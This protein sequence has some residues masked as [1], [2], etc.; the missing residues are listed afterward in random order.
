MHGDRP[1]ASRIVRLEAE[2]FKRLRA[3]EIEPDGNVVV[4]GG[5]NGQ[6]K[7]SLLDAIAAAL[8]GAAARPAIP[9]RAGEEKAVIVADLGDIIV[10]RVFTASGGTHLHVKNKEGAV[11]PSPQALLDRLAGKVTFDPLSF[12][13]QPPK[14]Q[15]ETLKQ[16]VGVDFDSL[17]QERAALY[18]E[19]RAVNRATQALKYQLDRMPLHEDVPP[20]AEEASFENLNAE[21]ERRRAHNRQRE[22][23]SAQLEG[24]IAD[25]EDVMRREAKLTEEIE[26]L[27]Q[28]LAHKREQLATT[29]Q[30]AKELEARQA[31]VQRAYDGFV[32]MDTSDILGQIRN[33]QE[34]NRKVVENRAYADMLKQVSKS[35]EDAD[36]LTRRIAAIDARKKEILQKAHF[37]VAGL[38]FGDGCVTLNGIPIEQASSAEQ[39]RVAVAISAA[40]NPHLRVVLIRDGSLLDKD[41]FALL[42]QLAEENDLQVW[43]EVVREDGDVQVLIEDGT[44]AAAKTTENAD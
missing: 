40:M 37:P 31:E 38:G 6:G 39:L 7:S 20:D 15:L 8:G 19:R 26:Q 35:E 14:Q 22:V 5:R 17:D 43:V 13:R 23:F 12:L 25:R 27:E 28:L 24:I 4:V 10:R 41:S 3:V 34:Y 36:A 42:R 1:S 21:L 11:F 33:L 18:E 32:G 30:S 2:N 29:Q 44:A 16:L 9:V